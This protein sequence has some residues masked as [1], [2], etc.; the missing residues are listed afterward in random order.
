M[1]ALEGDEWQEGTAYAEGMDMLDE[2]PMVPSAQPWCFSL[3]LEAQMGAVAGLQ[4][5]AYLMVDSG[6]CVHACPRDFADWNLVENAPQ[7]VA[8]MAD[9]REVR[10][11]GQRKVMFDLETGHTG[12][13]NFHVMPVAR[14]ILSV[15][16]M[17][18]DGFKVHLD[19]G[20]GPYV[21]KFGEKNYLVKQG[22]LFF[23]PV[24]L[25]RPNKAVAMITPRSKEETAVLGAGALPLQ[26]PIVGK[27]EERRW[28]LY[29]Y[30]C[31]SSSRLGEWFARHGHRVRRLGLPDRDL[32][33]PAEVEKVTREAVNDYKQGH[34][35]VL[36]IS[37]PCAPWSQWQ[38]L[39]AA[40]AHDKINMAR[41][42]SVWMIRLL[43]KAIAYMMRNIPEDH[44][45]RV[46]EWPRGAVGWKLEAM[47]PVLRTMPITCELDGC[48]YGL[49]SRGGEWLLKPWRIV[50]NCERL[51]EPLSRRCVRTHTHGECHGQD[52]AD[53]ERYTP[54]LVNEAGGAITNM[55]AQMEA[56]IDEE[57]TPGQAEAMEDGQSATAD[58]GQPEE[59]AT[60]VRRGVR[61]PEEPVMEDTQEELRTPRL[62]QTPEMPSEEEQRKHKCTHCPFAWWC[63]ECVAAKAA[64]D[65]HRPNPPCEGEVPVVELDY[66]AMKT[67]APKDVAAPILVGASRNDGHG[68]AVLARS[69]GRGDRDTLQEVM[70]WLNE[71][72][73]TGLLRL[74]TDHG[75]SIR[76]VA[77]EI[78]ARRQPARTVLEV[79]PV[80][81]H[82]SLGQAERMCRTIAGHLRALR[83]VVEEKWNVK[84]N[85]RSPCMPWLV[86]HAAWIHNRYQP[87]MGRT[88][89]ER[90]HPKKTAKT[91]YERVT[92]RVY[93]GVV[94][95]MLEP[96]MVRA[97]DV[98]K[99]PKMDPRWIPGLWLGRS[100]TSD[101][102][103]VGTPQGVMRGRSV[104][105]LP[106]AEAPKDLYEH[107]TWTPWCQSPAA[108]V[109][110]TEEK[111]MITA[112]GEEREEKKILVGPTGLAA[113]TSRWNEKT[114]ELRGFHA[115]CGQTPACLAC[116]EPEGKRH[117]PLC[118]Q[119]R[120]QWLKRVRTAMEETSQQTR[121]GQKERARPWSEETQDEPE[122]IRRRLTSKRRGIR[123]RPDGDEQKEK[124]PENVRR[125]L[126]SKQHVRPW[127]EI[128]VEGPERVSRQRVHEG[129]QGIAECDE[130]MRRGLK[131][132]ADREDEDDFQEELAGR[133][134]EDVKQYIAAMSG[135]PWL[136]SRTGAVLDEKMVEIGMESERASLRSYH[137]YTEVPIARVREVNGTLIRSRWV[138][139][140]KGTRVKARLVAQQ[141]NLGQWSD[142]YAATP[143]TPGQRIVLCLAARCG[144]ELK[145]GD[146][147]TAFLNAG[148]P[149]D[150][151]LF[152]L[153]PETERKPGMVWKLHRALYG[154]RRSPQLFQE[155]F[156]HELEA[157]GF[158]RLLSDPQVYVHEQTQ[159]LISAHVDDMMIAA[160]PECMKE[161]TGLI[162]DAFKIKWGDTVSTGQWSKFLGREWRRSED[163]GFRIRVPKKYFTGLLEEMGMQDSRIVTTPYVKSVTEN[164]ELVE[165]RRQAQYRHCVG[166]LM[167][168]IGE[169]PD[170]SYAIKECARHVQAPTEEHWIA[171]K[172]VLRYLRGTVSAEMHLEAR[173]ADETI[174]VVTDADW[175]ANADRRSTSGGTLWWH[176]MLLGAWSRTQ[177]T[178][179]QS[180]CESELVSLCTGVTEG[181]F[182]QSILQELKVDVKLEAHCDSTSATAWC[183]HR[184]MGRLRH[185]DVRQLWIQAEVRDQRL[186]VRRVATA[187]NVSDVL[188]KG[189]PAARF[190]QL[191]ARLGLTFEEV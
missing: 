179:A 14:A 182:V 82:S 120:T 187:D 126:I 78:A 95:T 92:G 55:M 60:L 98:E 49:R 123:P 74:R 127:S 3:E 89:M 153:P 129:Q 152:L 18:A 88:E 61:T 162:D 135:P 42:E 125:R 93:N 9:G 56:D 186:F 41:E 97:S 65:P 26:S 105:P 147:S 83:L 134:R 10:S 28:A 144:L 130:E 27:D 51:C 155:H 190:L 150:E 36:W 175:A 166:K 160:R 184:G 12:Q 90:E 181:K 11:E 113:P 106:T 174:H 21:E 87:V 23:L 124:E 30:C 4:D 85:M 2:V 191:V 103:L 8:R 6:A 66:A 13:A 167:W 119:R 111:P 76:A 94:F 172:R 189:L 118:R 114:R 67:S 43:A 146:V 177:A 131:R 29:E 79:T 109:K 73:L 68:L 39:N 100:A 69:M 116:R 188:T 142:A 20:T 58:G 75:P 173:D 128:G 96:V 112:G 44:F 185:L 149:A 46:F 45:V 19:G 165:A 140:D 139:A 63:Y 52:A 22:N 158:R 77:Q 84:L 32:R 99:R 81:S 108:M 156:A 71:S 138:L 171:M 141:L 145:F 148:L 31:G 70:E 132:A 169:R 183:M 121:A 161:V 54:E 48:A 117:T 24:R 91:P 72:G 33:E 143:T 110:Q 59:G 154:L 25:H 34:D 35:I 163:G 38:H 64:D 180:S 178:I 5:V 107:M 86:R 104:R 53:S 136:D 7:L 164:S 137:V 57:T 62:R 101:E 15:G 170:L 151:K 50:T 16:A 168:C 17:C 159:S 122:A 133:L 176:G 102:H 1:N 47:Q 157:R 40:K 80:A 115:D 37:L